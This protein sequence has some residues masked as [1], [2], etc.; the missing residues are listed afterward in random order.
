M[1]RN[2]SSSSDP[3]EF[4]KTR[5]VVVCNPMAPPLAPRIVID[6]LPALLGKIQAL[7]E[8][9][10]PSSN[11]NKYQQVARAVI[12]LSMVYKNLGK[13][14]YIQQPDFTDPAY[15]VA[16]VFQYF[17][18]HCHL[19]YQMLWMLL[20]ISIAKTWLQSGINICSIGGG[21]G[22]DIIGVL[23]YLR[24]I[25]S[26]LGSSA[27]ERIMGYVLDK[28]SA[29]GSTWSSLRESNTILK[30]SQIYCSY[31]TCNLLDELP[32][33][34]TEEEIR[35]A[36]LITMIKSLSAFNVFLKDGRDIRQCAV[37]KLLKQLKR[38]A[39]VLF[40]DNNDVM[41]RRTSYTGYKT[42]NTIF[43]EDMA[44][45]AGLRLLG[46]WHGTADTRIQRSEYHI[47][48]TYLEQFQLGPDWKSPGLRKCAV[49]V[50]L[51][52]RP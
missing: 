38:G 48:K 47:L 10:F 14:H 28:Y 7:D 1:A 35:Q 49:S 39:L 50:F 37:T 32:T 51:L 2:N 9:Y 46:A 13:A 34:A 30:E 27:R 33:A 40:I 42:Q 25:R 12:T 4:Q 43:L 22:T 36:D 45:P 8:Y 29:W 16:Y 26:Y 21:P 18:K 5:A 19:I 52:Q 31:I 15:Q 3:R 6:A 41:Y 44:K 20:P 11:C 24:S 23:I 17:T